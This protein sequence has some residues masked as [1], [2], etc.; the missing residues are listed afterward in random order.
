[1]GEERYCDSNVSPV[2]EQLRWTLRGSQQDR[3][4][5]AV[6]LGHRMQ[7]ECPGTSHR[8]PAPSRGAAVSAAPPLDTTPMTS[9]RSGGS[10]GIKA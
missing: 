10:P 2:A 9:A 1:M 3:P 6:A 4:R 7:G 8:A 5:D